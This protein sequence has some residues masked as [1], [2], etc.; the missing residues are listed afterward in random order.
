MGKTERVLAPRVRNFGCVLVVMVILSFSM[1]IF[2][3]RRRTG[4][5]HDRQKNEKIN[6]GS[7]D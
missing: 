3:G 5:G 2:Q 4:M 6:P 7:D 1:G